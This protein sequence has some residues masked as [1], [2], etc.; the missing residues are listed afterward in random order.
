MA[1]Y[2]T[3]AP[4][5]GDGVLIDRCFV[6]IL[7]TGNEIIHSALEFGALPS[8]LLINTIL[9]DEGD[10][11]LWVRADGYIFPFLI[12]LTV[13][14]LDGPTESTPRVVDV[15][16]T[17]ASTSPEQTAGWAMVYGW[18]GLRLPG[19]TPSRGAQGY[20]VDE[21]LP[22][23][24]IQRYDRVVHIW[25]VGP[26]REGE[27]ATLQDREYLNVAVDRNGYYEILLVPATLYRIAVPNVAGRR[28]FTTLG[29]GTSTEVETLIETTLSASPYE[30]LGGIG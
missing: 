30:I 11:L 7:S 21:R 25:R 15:Q 3:F 27:S 4:K 8:S 16:A 17:G 28:Y 5:D 6:S 26:A 18:A 24:N 2:I 29:A 13:S 19:T 23:G 22:R 14:A 20:A 9:L 1:E 12:P 10:Y